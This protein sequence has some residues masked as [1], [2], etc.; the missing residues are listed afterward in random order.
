MLKR[1]TQPRHF[2]TLG[3]LLL[4]VAC[5]S[6]LDTPGEALRILGNTFPTAYLNEDY[7]GNIRVVGGLSPYSYQL[8]DGILPPGLE[9]QGG[10]LTG[11]PTEEGTYTFTLT[12]SDGNLSTTFQ[13][14]SL[15][16]TL[17]PPP[18]LVFNPPFTEVRRPVTMRVEVQEARDLQALRTR[19]TWDASKFAFSEG[20]VKTSNRNYAA[21]YAAEQGQ[22]QVDFAV[23]G[24]TIN[25]NK[26]LF[27]FTLTPL[28]S[29]TLLLSTD[30]EYIAFNGDHYFASKDEGVD[31]SDPEEVTPLAPAEPDAPT[32]APDDASDAQEDGAPVETPADEAP[33]EGEPPDLPPM[34]DP[35][36][37][38]VFLKQNPVT[39]VTINV[40]RSQ[41]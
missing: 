3:L 20:S 40:S 41:A 13:D 7:T 29:S 19:I 22:L 30:T 18:E 35:N 23:L 14:Y 34:D 21:F 15:T 37:E 12:V 6:E 24:S 32:V 25:G 28:E 10:R 39:T 2:L 11:V 9:L 38:G 1:V 5:S 4:L 31:S 26:R 27:E 36:P 33:A 17:A 8:S 16:V